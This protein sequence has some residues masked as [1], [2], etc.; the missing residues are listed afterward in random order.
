MSFETPLTL[1]GPLRA[2][3]QLLAHQTYDGHSS[4][5]DDTVAQKLGL[6]AGPIEGPTH[7]SQYDPLLYRIWGQAWFEQG[8]VSAHYQNM[9]VAG[10]EVR[11][12]AE[13]PSGDTAG[14]LRIWVEKRDGTPVQEASATLGP[15]HGRTLLEERMAKLSPPDRLV[16]LEHLKVGMTGR[17]DEH[18]SMSQDRQLGGLYPFSLNEKLAV[19]TENSPWYSD[20]TA[21]PWGRAIIPMEMISALALCT[22]DEA[23]FPVKG[24]SVG[25]LADQEIRMIEGPLFVDEEYVLR[26]EIVALSESRRTESYWMLTR[27]FD[28]TGKKQVAEMLVN[29]ARLKASYAGYELESARTSREAN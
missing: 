29:S 8:C 19:I 6:K 23:G 12:F 5:H 24:P 17:R 10:E 26:R 2:P 15:E 9:V 22:L 16:I 28:R 11:A 13:M 21:S 7:F 14:P 25:L 18:V 3:K 4:I 20:P 27:I 1:S